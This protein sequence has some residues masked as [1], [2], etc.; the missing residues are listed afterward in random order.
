MHG[1]MNIK[2][3]CTA[4]AYLCDVGLGYRSNFTF[5]FDDF[6]ITKEVFKVHNLRLQDCLILKI[7]ALLSVEKSGTIY[8]SIRCNILDDLALYQCHCEKRISFH[9]V[10]TVFV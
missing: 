3:A 1:N 7:K 10:S 4:P 6:F 2:F 9:F 8:Q 5:Y